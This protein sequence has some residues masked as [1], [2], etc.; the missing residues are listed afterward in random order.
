MTSSITSGHQREQQLI[1]HQSHPPTV[2]QDTLDPPSGVLK[3]FPSS[4]CSL[5]LLLLCLCPPLPPSDPGPAQ[6]SSVGLTTAENPRRE[7]M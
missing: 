4:F 5:L 3:L 6:G 2:L 1:K 7:A